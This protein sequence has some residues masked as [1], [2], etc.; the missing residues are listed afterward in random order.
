MNFYKTKKS[1]GGD[2]DHAVIVTVKLGRLLSVF[3]HSWTA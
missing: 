3:A 1:G 2:T